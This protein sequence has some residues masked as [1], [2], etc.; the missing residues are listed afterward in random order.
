[1]PNVA[2]KIRPGC[3]S[4]IDDPEHAEREHQRDQVRVDQRVEQAL[5]E[6]HL[7]GRHVGA[8]GVQ[9]E[10]LRDRLAAVDLVQQRGQGGR[11]HVDHV[12][13][14]RRVGR[15]VRGHTDCSIGPIDVSSVGLRQHLQ[16]RGGVV[17][18][19]PAQVAL[20][21]LAAEVDRRR[22]ADVRLRGHRED[23]RRLADP[24]AGRGG[25][26]AVGRDVDDH[27][28]L[29]GEL[30]LDDLPHRL[31]EPAR[32]VEQE[33][34]RVVAALVRLRNLAGQ[35]VLGDGIDVV[36][37]LD[38][39]HARGVRRRLGGSVGQKERREQ[40]ER[41]G[42]CSMGMGAQESPFHSRKDS[43][44]GCPERLCGGHTGRRDL[45]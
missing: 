34:D 13:L 35:V 17:D 15:E 44:N 40:G 45:L 20:D 4:S 16:R 18:D 43:I 3:Q 33:H 24:D 22:R 27:R 5:P 29:R 28:D 38:R 1:M 21:V 36:V 11:G 2:G 6:A 10:A 14:E 25:P 42:Q 39:E 30:L 19:L 32:R 31:R 41:G 23:V 8:R 7:H 12:L 26:R 9:D 37:E